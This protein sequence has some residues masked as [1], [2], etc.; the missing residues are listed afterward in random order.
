MSYRVNRT[1]LVDSG[2]W[3]ALF[4]ER[5]EHHEDAVAKA[6]EIGSF[7]NLLFPWPILYETINTRLSRRPRVIRAFESFLKRPGAVLL[8]DADYRES[9]LDVAL[10]GHREVERTL[11]LVDCVIRLII[12]DANVKV[13]CIYTYNRRDFLDVCQRHRVE[14]VE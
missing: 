12:E 2:F 6:E 5:D 9:A 4:N 1:A 8:D 14:L 13:D 7:R 10:F 11:S 3:F